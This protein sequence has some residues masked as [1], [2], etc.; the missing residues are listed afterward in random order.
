MAALTPERAALWGALSLAL[1]GA[2]QLPTFL[3]DVAAFRVHVTGLARAAHARPQAAPAHAGPAVPLRLPNLPP[4]PLR[5]PDAADAPPAYSS[6]SVVPLVYQPEPDDPVRPD[7]DPP[8]VLPA[9][10]GPPPPPPR[11][12]AAAAGA[13]A[14]GAAPMAGVPAILADLPPGAGDSVRSAPR[15]LIGAY[16]FHRPEPRQGAGAGAPGGSQSA[17]LLRYRPAPLAERPLM[18][19]VRLLAAHDW[20]PGDPSVFRST[21]ATAGLGWLLLPEVGGTLTAERWIR[22]D[23]DS[24]SAFALRAHGGYGEG[25]GPDTPGEPWPHWSLYGEAAVVGARRRDLY[26]AAEARAGYGFALGHARLMLTAG[27]WGAAQ[28]DDRLRHRLEAGPGLGLD[29]HLGETPL[30]L[31]LDYRTALSA[32]RAGDGG[33]TLTVSAGL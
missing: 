17:L 3:A 28:K 12:G 4:Q 14:T 29:T 9:G 5:L 22:T 27:L 26:A 24:R 1:W 16:V 2:L 32:T 19:T 10:M 13:A 18:L 15:L 33:L 6:D 8:P 30:H 31:R 20:P 25:W 7:T 21:Q 11:P 23:R